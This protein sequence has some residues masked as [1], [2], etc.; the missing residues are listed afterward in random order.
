[1]ALVTGYLM[2]R[3]GR[4]LGERLLTPASILLFL[5]YAVGVNQENLLAVTAS[6]LVLFLAIR[7]LG[8]KSGRNYLQIFALSLFCLAASSL[9]NL[10]ALFL[11]Y[12]LLLLLLLAVSLVVLTFHAHDA[13]I[14]L[15]RPELKCVLGVAGLMPVAALPMLLVLFVT[16]PRTQFPLWDFLNRGAGSQAGLSDQVK[17][18]A[19]ANVATVKTVVLRVLSPKVPESRLYWRGI[20]LNGF[21]DGAWVRLGDPPEQSSVAGPGP[22]IHQEIYPEPGGVPYLVALNM[23]RQI[24][25]LRTIDAPDLVFKARYSLEKR[26]KYQADSTLADVVRV[27]GGIQREFYLQVPETVSARF[28]EQAR[29]LAGPGLTDGQK[30]VQLERFI[31]G[32]RISYANTGLPTGTQALDEFLFVKK[33]GNCEFFASSAAILLRLAG[34][35]AR[36]VGGYRGGN[37]NEMGGYYQ[38]TDD[39]A[40]VWVE[41]FLAGKGWVTLDPTAWSLGFVRQ[42]GVGERLRLYV[43]AI[44]FYWNKAVLT[45]DLDRQISLLRNAGS[46]ARQLHLPTVTGKNLLTVVAWLMPLAGILAWLLWRPASREE[47][48]LRRFL[49]AVRQRYPGGEERAGLFELAEWTGDP[50]VREFAV[51]YGAALYGDRR[52]APEELEQLRQ[53][54]G[55]LAKH[56]S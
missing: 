27:K 25:G 7:M 32:Q 11:I 43:D 35:P 23:P 6:L 52:L 17:P 22:L 54:V 14:A 15:A 19:S 1:V 24:S 29:Q 30:L 48:L 44:G 16:L 40:H 46:K 20:V 9:Y 31:R 5:Y 42:Q 12:L 47:R 41:A 34:V 18:G 13:E 8:E 51:I 4:F 10:S 55:G 38:V 2:E 45:Y 39:M 36:L 56:R 26:L 3:S 53:I 50:L 49:A 21:R 28:R 37:Y 33:R